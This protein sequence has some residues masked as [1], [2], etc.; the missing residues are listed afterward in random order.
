MRRAH[1]EDPP[2][3][4]VADDVPATQKINPDLQPRSRHPTRLRGY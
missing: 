4:R 3:R 2:R 1:D